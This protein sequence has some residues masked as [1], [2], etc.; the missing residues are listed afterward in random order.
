MRPK[1]NDDRLE[2]GDSQRGDF[3]SE[4]IVSDFDDKD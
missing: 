2:V 3:P 1:I 4:K